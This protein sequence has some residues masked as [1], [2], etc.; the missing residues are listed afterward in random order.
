MRFC[1]Q[2]YMQIMKVWLYIF[3]GR[4][5]KISGWI[6]LETQISR[7]RYIHQLMS[8]LNSRLATQLTIN[9]YVFDRVTCPAYSKVGQDF[10]QIWHGSL[11]DDKLRAEAVATGQPWMDGFGNVDLSGGL[12]NPIHATSYALAALALWRNLEVPWAAD[13]AYQGVK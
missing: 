1:M 4:K 7:S 3:Q 10:G 9:N 6:K 5:R 13:R 12:S 2:C 11:A 8:I